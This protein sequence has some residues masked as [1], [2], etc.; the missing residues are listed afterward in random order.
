MAQV[1]VRNLEDD[2]R[3][4]LRELARSRGQSMEETVREILR[5]AVTGKPPESGEAA[6]DAKPATEKSS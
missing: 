2:V 1:I 5:S 4:K 3:D 6:K